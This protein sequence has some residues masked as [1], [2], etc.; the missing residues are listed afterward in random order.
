VSLVDEYRRRRWE[1]ATDSTLMVLSLLFRRP[2]RWTT[3]SASATYVVG[4]TVLFM[5]VAS[6]AALDA[7][8][9]RSGANIVIFKDA[10]WWSFASSA[11]GH[12]PEGLA[13]PF[14]R[15]RW[16]G[17]A[18]HQ[19]DL[20]ANA[21][22]FDARAELVSLLIE[23]IE[24]DQYP[25]TTMLDMLEQNLAPDEVPVYVAML[26]RRVRSDRFPSIP[27]LSRL[28]KYA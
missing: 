28:Q 27:M 20:M 3:S 21:E 9:G 25:S 4:G 23:K 10:V 11:D 6:L 16:R 1:R 12:R 26:T 19:G 18:T 8:R 22:D 13:H 24:N 5:F 15:Y 2:S 14:W 17:K 7:E